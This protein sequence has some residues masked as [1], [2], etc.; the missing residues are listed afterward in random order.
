MNK[1]DW[2]SYLMSLAYFVAQKSKDP[3]THIGA[4]LIGYEHEIISTGYNGMPVHVNDDVPERNERPEKY[5][6]YE[7]AERNAIYQ[8]ARNGIKTRGRTMYTIG[9]PCADCARAIIQ[10]G[11]YEVVVDKRWDERYVGADTK[12][13]E[14]AK[15][16][17]VMFM[18]SGVDLRTYEGPLIGKIQG[19]FSGNAFDLET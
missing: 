1:I 15:R 9:T 5:L 14:Q 3:S 16:V 19:F 2:D 4:V 11:I 6:W 8:A 10:A 7:H 18:E 17:R 12:W 13:A